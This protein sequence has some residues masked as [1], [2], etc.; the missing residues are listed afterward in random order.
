[1]RKFVILLTLLLQTLVGLAQDS[2]QGLFSLKGMVQNNEKQT[3][4][5]E[6]VYLYLKVDSS[7]VKTEFTDQNGNFHFQS[8]KQNS[9]FISVRNP[10]FETFYSE[11]IDVKADL[12]LSNLILQKRKEQ[13]VKEVEIAAKK[14][15]IERKAGKMII[16]VEQSL[17]A[18]GSSA[19]EVIERSP[20]VA[21]S[22]TDQISLNG[23]Q[24]IVVQINGKSLQMSGT[25]LA[26]YLRGIPSSN[27]EKIEFITNPSSKYDA[28]GSVLIDIRL[29][30]DTR[31]GTNGTIG[32]TYGQGVYPKSNSSLTLNHRT[33]K[34]N[35]FSNYS[36]AYR[37]SFNHLQL[38][39]KFYQ[40][41]TFKLAYNQNNY[42]T[43]PFK[44]H[45]LRTGFDYQIDSTSTLSFVM[46]GVSNK[47]NPTGTNI[48]D[49]Y[50]ENYERISSFQTVNNSFDNWYS[51]GANLNYRKNLDTL[52]STFSTDLDYARYGNQTE[53]NFTTNYYDLNGQALQNPYL[54][55]GDLKG[56]LD[57]YALKLDWKKGFK[58]GSSL[59][60]GGKTSYVKADNNIQFFDR[61]SG[62]D[63]FDSLKSNHFIYTEN[64]NALYVNYNFEY[65]KWTYQLGLRTENTNI[66]GNQLVYNQKF[67]T[68]YIQLYPSIS[69]RYK[70]NDKHSFDF[71]I[72]RRIDRPSY[73]Q[74]NPFKFY[75]DPTTYKEGNPYL[76]P[77]TT[78]TAEIGHQFK[79]NFYSLLGYART[80]D[81][82]TEIIAPSAQAQNITVQTNINLRNVDLVYTNFSLPFELKKWW[83]MRIDLNAYLALYSG[84]AANTEIRKSGSYNANINMVHQFKLSK[85]QSLELTGNYRTREVYAFDSIKQ[86]WFVSFGYQAKILKNKGTIRLGLTDMFFSNQITADVTF[87][88]Y[89]ENFLVKRE[90]RVATIAFTYRFGSAQF[91]AR[92][93]A[94]GAEDLKQRVGGQGNG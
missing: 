67:D 69:M 29:K 81:N 47:F 51:A 87:T 53:Q 62:T 82:I 57:I 71:N 74:L 93:R 11:V 7:L 54:L 79:E 21:V 3:L 72:N 73:D 58:N 25:D 9:Y 20:G 44:N 48:S 50:D 42:L 32:S 66:T 24:G 59:E 31:F 78:I 76:R 37:K 19:F 34:W 85:N 15:Y 86:I 33:K 36:F 1:M 60:Y 14:P 92:R 8:L 23:K 65:K 41:D 10:E 61:S 75:L 46:N 27:I 64:I 77:Q 12:N 13:T 52:G 17:Q 43:F 30:K 91:S 56:N 39:R 28:S 4:K 26:N 18:T 6:L 83:S 49:V 89:R 94:G 45:I 35:F 84:N 22:L 38:E 2:L 90:T 80:H 68:S 88:D 70:A 63:I 16:N 40:N 55:Y 5:D